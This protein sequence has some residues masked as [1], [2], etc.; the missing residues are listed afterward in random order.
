MGEIEVYDTEKK[1]LVRTFDGHMSRVGSLAWNDNLIASGSRDRMILLSDI[2]APGNSQIKYLGHRQEICG[3]KW[4]FDQQ[5][6]ASGGNDN[7][8]FV[9]SLRKAGKLASFS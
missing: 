7:K 1:K 3:L 4:S 8:L 5:L 6:L 2:R 9:W